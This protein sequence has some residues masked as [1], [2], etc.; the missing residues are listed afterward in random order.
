MSAVAPETA[1]FIASLPVWVTVNDL[2]VVDPGTAMPISPDRPTVEPFG[3]T[4]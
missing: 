1:I 4:V 3:A 2:R